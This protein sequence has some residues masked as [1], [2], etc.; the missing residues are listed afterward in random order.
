ME[1]QEYFAPSV[2]IVHF[3]FPS[4][5]CLSDPPIGGGEGS[6]EQPELP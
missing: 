2:A 3:S 5:L 6:G 4:I 1:K